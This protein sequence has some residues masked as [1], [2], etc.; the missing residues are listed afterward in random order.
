MTAE[1]RIRSGVGYEGLELG[2][3]S[4][5]L[6]RTCASLRAQSFNIIL[7]MLYLYFLLFILI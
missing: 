4:V 5:N 1:N 2:R 3:N 6:P 7:Y